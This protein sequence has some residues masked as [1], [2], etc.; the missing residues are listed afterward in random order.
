MANIHAGRLER[1]VRLAGKETMPEFMDCALF[2]H[3]AQYAE[4]RYCALR[5]RL[6]VV[7]AP[8]TTADCRL[9]SESALRIL[10]HCKADTGM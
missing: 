9:R 4:Y 3:S 7:F 1:R 2:S 6:T 5:L 10:T 8:S